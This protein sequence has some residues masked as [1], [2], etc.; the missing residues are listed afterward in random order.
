MNVGFMLF[1]LG[2]QRQKFY[3]KDYVLWPKTIF[4]GEMSYLIEANF[5]KV[6]QKRFE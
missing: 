4:H 5:R 2:P 6:G 1:L 3:M